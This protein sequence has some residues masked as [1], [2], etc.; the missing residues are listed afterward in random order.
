MPR[1][2]LMAKWSFSAGSNV[3][4]SKDVL[5]LA[6][7][8]TLP[9]TRFLCAFDKDIVQTGQGQVK[10]CADDVGAVLKKLGSLSVLKETFDTAQLISG[11]TLKPQKCK[12]IFLVC[13][14]TEQVKLLVKQ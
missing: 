3:A 11:L 2:W 10:A 14:L 4:S 9:L 7:S 8:L 1:L 6:S 5:H 12:I 13:K